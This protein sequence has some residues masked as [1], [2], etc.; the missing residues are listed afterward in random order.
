MNA[1]YLTPL[2]KGLNRA[3]RLRYIMPWLGLSPAF[4]STIFGSIAFIVF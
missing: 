4:T 1:F 3:M 2:A